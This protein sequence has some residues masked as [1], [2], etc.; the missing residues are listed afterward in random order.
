MA[1]TYELSYFE[2]DA[3]LTGTTFVYGFEA[4]TEGDVKIIG[5]IADVQTDLSST[6]STVNT[7][8]KTLTLSVA[9][10]G[11]DKI[12]IYRSTTVLP[13]VDF[14]DGAVLSADSLNTAYKHS[15]FAAQEVVQGAADTSNNIG[16]SLVFTANI[17]NGAVTSDKLAAD[18]VIATKLADNCVLDEHIN[19]GAVTSTKLA[20]LSVTAGKL[21]TDSVTT[22]K[23]LDANVT[24][25]KLEN[26]L[27]LSAKTLTLPAINNPFAKQLLYVVEEFASGVA[28]GASTATT[29]HIRALNVVVENGIVGASLNI[30][31]YQVTLPAGEYFFDYISPAHKTGNNF[32]FIYQVSPSPAGI[33]GNGLNALSANSDGTVTTSTGSNVITLTASSTVIELRHY[34]QATQALNGLGV[35]IGFSGRNERYASLKIWKIA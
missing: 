22:A 3:G 13:L 1:T 24:A 15:L 12:R 27:D 5:Y 33:I 11:Y 19:I 2:T 32:S 21:T 25:G 8:T 7:S 18:S 16:T 9:P 30:S 26:T 14:T 34:M 31:T 10:T 28:A 23:I 6:I 20:N 29:Q 17:N 35:P 4:L